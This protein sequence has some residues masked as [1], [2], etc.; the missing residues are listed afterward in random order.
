MILD[1]P[2]AKKVKVESREMVITDDRGTYGLRFA[3]RLG[4]EEIRE[5][6]LMPEQIV[7]VAGEIQV[8]GTPGITIYSP[9]K[10]KDDFDRL[11]KM[12]QRANN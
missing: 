9:I 3:E 6:G 8:R 7:Y 10:D 2:R 5:I 11:N 12:I 4:T 1:K